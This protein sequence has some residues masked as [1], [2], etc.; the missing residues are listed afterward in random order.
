[1]ILGFSTTKNCLGLLNPM[2][3]IMFSFQV[4]FIQGLG[5]FLLLV[6]VT[7]VL[8]SRQGV[9]TWLT[10]DG[11]AY[12]VELNE[13]SAPDSE[14]ADQSDDQVCQSVFK[15]SGIYIF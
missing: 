13:T 3:N 6:I 11:R 10:S 9:E 12:F 14:I 2:V 4:C 7:K 15:K 1:M 8:H 5:I